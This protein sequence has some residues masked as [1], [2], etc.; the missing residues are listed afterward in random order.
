MNEDFMRGMIDA[1]A[2]YLVGWL[3]RIV[4]RYLL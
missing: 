4:V 1:A 2:V 3:V